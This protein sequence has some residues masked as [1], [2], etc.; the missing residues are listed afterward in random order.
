MPA[1]A[2]RRNPA[3]PVRAALPAARRIVRTSRAIRSR[4]LPGVA[5][6]YGD[7]AYFRLGSVRRVLRAAIPAYVR[8]VLIAQRASFTMSSLR[9]QPPTRSSAL[10]LFTS[11][12]ELHAR[13][14][15]LMQPVFRKSRIEAYA[16]PHGGPV[17]PH[18]RPSGESG[19]DDRRRRRNDEADHAHRRAKTLF[20]HDIEDDTQR[21]VAQHRSPG[22]RVLHPAVVAVPAASRSTLPLPLH[23]AR[24]SRRCATSTTVIYRMIE[25]RQAPSG[26]ASDDLLSLLMQAKDDET[27]V[28]MTEKQLRDEV[29]TLLIA[30]HETT[31]NVLALDPFISWRSD[32]TADRAAARGGAV[33]AGGRATLRAAADIDRLP[34]RGRVMHGGPAALSAGLVHRPRRRWRT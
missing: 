14:R 17:A 11:R 9:D 22:A 2:V 6:M 27:H 21:G 31:A 3:R 25:R 10:G 28:H 1:S 34:I 5:R 29:L 12:G 8:E 7:I 16:A 33:G 13:Q 30:G 26:G 15:R 23:A 4:S 20:E 19:A 24:S 18:A 32:P